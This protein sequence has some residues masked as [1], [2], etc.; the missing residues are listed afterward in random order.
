MCH[1]ELP[2]HRVLVC[3]RDPPRLIESPLARFLRPAHYNVYSF[4]NIFARYF[5][6]SARFRLFILQANETIE[7]RD[8]DPSRSRR[9]IA[10][11]PSYLARKSISLSLDRYSYPHNTL[12]SLS[13]VFQIFQIRSRYTNLDEK[14]MRMFLV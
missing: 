2:N 12:M 5:A 10:D 1:R 11:A 7:P 3:Y 8:R 9:I 4:R 14:K 6:C 13:N